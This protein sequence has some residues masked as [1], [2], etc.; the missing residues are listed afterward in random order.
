MTQLLVAALFEVTGTEC[1]VSSSKSGTSRPFTHSP[2]TTTAGTDWSGGF[3]MLGIA[4][5]TALAAL[6]AALRRE[7]ASA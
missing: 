3:R 2:V 7:V 4:A 1:L 6:L 5:V